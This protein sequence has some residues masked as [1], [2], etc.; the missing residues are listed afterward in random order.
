MVG[1]I[2]S[3]TSNIL[4]AEKVLFFG[5]NRDI[6]HLFSISSKGSTNQTFGKFGLDTIRMRANLGLSGS[7]FT[8]GRIMI[9]REIKNEQES[10][11]EN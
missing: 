11:S 4:K 10:K 3:L 1:D 8:Q 2:N 7:A 9:E 6:D 5:Y